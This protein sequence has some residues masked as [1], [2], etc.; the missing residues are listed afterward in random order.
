MT[1]YEK[2]KSMSK[3]EMA[4]AICDLL[5]DYG[6]RVEKEVGELPFCAFCP[7]TDKCFIDHNGMCEWLGEEADDEG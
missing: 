4:K 6:R 5:E 2:I 3:E 7:A 1:R